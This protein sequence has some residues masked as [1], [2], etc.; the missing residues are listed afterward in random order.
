MTS[1][2][3]FDP[4]RSAEWLIVLFADSDE[5]HLMLGDLSE[6]FFRLASQSG[7]VAARQW[8]WRQTL[9]SLPHL[10][11]SAFSMSPWSTIALVAAGFLLRRLLA[12][13][14]DLLTFAL[15]DKFDIYENHF[16]FYKFLASTALDMEHVLIFLFVGCVIALLA[17]RRE[18]APAIALAMIYSCMALFAS[19]SFAITSGHYA[20][21]WRLS[22]YFTDALAIVVG[23]VIVRA[24]RS[25]GTGW[26]L[27]R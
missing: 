20:I 1:R 13:L 16:A 23:A 27:Q 14:P 11:G 25:R 6:E 15:V 18:L 8:Y 7:R 24:S 22:W 4:P 19:A 2:R 21:L 17:R 26:S 5:A 12:R 3:D 9:K 10:V